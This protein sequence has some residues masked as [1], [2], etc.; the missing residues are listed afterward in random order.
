[1]TPE[2]RVDPELRAQR[3]RKSRKQV[4]PGWEE[5]K[6]DWRSSAEWARK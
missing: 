5:W 1:M 6:K 3:Q 4:P 2:L